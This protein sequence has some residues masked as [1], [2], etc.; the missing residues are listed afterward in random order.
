MRAEILYMI[1]VLIHFIYITVQHI[2]EHW[3]R[4]T[5]FIGSVWVSIA[6]DVNSNEVAFI[7]S[8]STSFIESVWVQMSLDVVWVE[9]SS[10]W[11]LIS[12]VSL[13]DAESCSPTSS[14]SNSY[15]SYWLIFGPRV[16]PKGSLVITSVVRVSVRLCVR[17]S[18]FKYLRDRSLVFSSFLHKVRAP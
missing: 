6:L 17:P 5:S 13:L 1:D 15:L 14:S 10:V 18:V 11:V 4:S 12:F 3:R 8:R 2:F 16:Y 7:L 9:E